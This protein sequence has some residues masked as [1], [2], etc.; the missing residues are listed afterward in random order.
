MYTRAPF[1]PEDL[2]D[3]FWD[4]I[5]RADKDDSKLE[6]ILSGLSAD[7]LYR[8]AV[9]F[10]YASDNLRGRPYIDYYRRGESKSEDAIAD[11]SYWVVSQGKEFYVNA[12]QHP[13]SIAAY[14][15][16]NVPAALGFEFTAES[17]LEDRLGEWPDTLGEYDRFLESGQ[18]RV[19]DY[20]E[21]RRSSNGPSED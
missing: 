4:I 10:M 8:F 2:S 5:Q 17:I 13:E 11:M 15:A 19:S 18:A 7:Q 9:E 3:W 14:E 16:A 6:E 1:N 12:W 21:T 20:W